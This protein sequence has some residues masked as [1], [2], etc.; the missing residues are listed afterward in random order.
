MGTLAI[1]DT[2][3]TLMA[4]GG[5]MIPIMQVTLAITPNHTGS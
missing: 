1:P 5:M 3:K 4:M 2:T